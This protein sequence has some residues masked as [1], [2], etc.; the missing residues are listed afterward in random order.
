MITASRARLMTASLLAVVSCSTALART[1]KCG[2]KARVKFL[3]A[4]TLI[5]G[6]FGPNEDTYLAE[7]GLDKKSEHILVRLIDAYP[8]QTPPILGEGL[9]APSGSTQRARRDF[10]CDPSCWQMIM[11]TAPGDPMG[12]FAG[13]T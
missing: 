4:S 3:A 11:R 5:R 12:D 2:Q 9:T 13:T 8:N 10:G 7:L 1:Q 6:T